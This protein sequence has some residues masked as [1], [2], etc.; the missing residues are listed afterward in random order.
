MPDEL[1]VVVSRLPSVLKRDT[2]R[3]VVVEIGIGKFIPPDTIFPSVWI[4]RQLQKKL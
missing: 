1:N 4:D 3:F 2:E